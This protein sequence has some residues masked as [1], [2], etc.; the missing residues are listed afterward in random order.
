MSNVLEIFVSEKYSPKAGFWLVNSLPVDQCMLRAQS[1]HTVEEFSLLLL[2]ISRYAQI[3]FY[4]Y[5]KN[6]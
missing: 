4:Y 3:I 5:F 6:V 1:T 2:D